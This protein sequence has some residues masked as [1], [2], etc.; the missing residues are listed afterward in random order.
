MFRLV[1]ITSALH[2]P[3]ALAAPDPDNAPV[4]PRLVTLTGVGE[5][6]ADLGWLHAAR[7]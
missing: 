5:R 1:L 6:W 7:D 3:S 2:A 4:E